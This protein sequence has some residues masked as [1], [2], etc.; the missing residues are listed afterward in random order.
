[1][2]P[3]KRKGG[4]RV[5]PK[6]TRPGESKLPVAAGAPVRTQDAAYHAVEKSSRYQPPIP[7]Y[8]K[9][10]PRWVPILMFCLLG[11]GLLTIIGYY[12]IS[13]MRHQYVLFGGLALILGGLYTATKW[14]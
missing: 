5:T 10:S 2:A 1:V 12:L 8:V 13:P 3:P 4:G 14:H 6:G 11:F 7:K 9:E